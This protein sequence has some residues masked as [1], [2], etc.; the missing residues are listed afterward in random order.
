MVD[1]SLCCRLCDG[2]KKMPKTPNYTII[3]MFLCED[4]MKKIVALV[5][6]TIMND[7]N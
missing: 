5:S 3:M 4:E 2:Q 1:K 6:A 7:K